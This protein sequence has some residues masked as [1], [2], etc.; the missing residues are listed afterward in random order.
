[1][2]TAAKF[3]HIETVK[4]LYERYSSSI[5]TKDIFGKNII[6]LVTKF[7]QFKENTH[8]HFPA[9][10]TITEKTD[11]RKNNTS[12]NPV[13]DYI[14]DKFIYEGYLKYQQKE[15]SGP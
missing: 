7:R 13:F 6:L 3:G 1:M 15:Y 11:F 9:D 8:K 2:L 10:G 5:L 4:M 12:M 14:L